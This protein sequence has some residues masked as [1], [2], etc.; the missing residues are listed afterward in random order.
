MVLILFSKKHIRALKAIWDID[1]TFST[2]E[3]LV[4]LQFAIED[5]QK[6]NRYITTMQDECKNQVKTATGLID[7]CDRTMKQ[8]VDEINQNNK[9]QLSKNKQI[10]E[11]TLKANQTQIRITQ[12]EKDIKSTRK[13]YAI[14]Q[15][16]LEKDRALLVEKTK[17]LM[18]KLGDI[19]PTCGRRRRG[20]GSIMGRVGGV[21]GSVISSVVCI[22]KK[23]NQGCVPRVPQNLIDAMERQ[24]KKT[25]EAYQKS[26]QGAIKE[27]QKLFENEQKLIAERRKAVIEGANMILQAET[28]T[29]VYNDLVITH[30]SLAYIKAQIQDIKVGFQ[31]LSK[32]FNDWFQIFTDRLE[33]VKDNQNSLER[34]K[35]YRTKKNFERIWKRQHK[36]L[37]DEISQ[38][39]LEWIAI[40]KLSYTSAK[41]I[42]AINE[43]LNDILKE[44]DLS[45]I[46]GM[47]K[48]KNERLVSLLEAEMAD[49]QQSIDEIDDFKSS[50]PFADTTLGHAV[51]G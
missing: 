24:H 44:S 1:E 5:L 22:F 31:R 21:V 29:G 50:F 42:Q 2:D 12:L 45:K 6:S 41:E 17:E 14:K 48:V 25:V 23:C 51:N 20:L 10:R 49:A 32:Y 13:N 3:S 40:G 34:A 33:D 37:K 15:A 47:L 35:E 19:K 27:K 39:A 30:V 18:G 4:M 38:S 28:E 46:E 36:L 7:Q 8:A 9:Q 43:N 16:K 11:L 26:M